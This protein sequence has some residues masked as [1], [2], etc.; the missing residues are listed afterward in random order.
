MDLISHAVGGINQNSRRSSERERLK[1]GQFR[2]SFMSMKL[3][4]VKDRF[5]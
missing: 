2:H 1:V 4:K 3:L 5:S